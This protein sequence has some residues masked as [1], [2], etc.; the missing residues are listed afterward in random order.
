MHAGRGNMAFSEASYKDD[1]GGVCSPGLAHGRIRR[2]TPQ[3]RGVPE[4]DVT[5]DPCN[6]SRRIPVRPSHLLTALFVSVR[7]VIFSSVC[8]TQTILRAVLRKVALR[9]HVT[10]CT[11]ICS[12]IALDQGPNN[13]QVLQ[14]CPRPRY[15][16]AS[17]ARRPGHQSI[18][19]KV[20]NCHAT[21]RIGDPRRR[22]IPCPFPCDRRRRRRPVFCLLFPKPPFLRLSPPF[23]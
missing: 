14:G 16:K 7:A 21:R 9:M 3:R 6:V 11:H 19:C 8:Y 12:L 5:Y 1:Q 15:Q 4:A 2:P 10:A 17:R 20:A 18:P 22:P 13:N 23:S